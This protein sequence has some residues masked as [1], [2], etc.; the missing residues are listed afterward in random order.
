M[1]GVIS[2]ARVLDTVVPDP[3][4]LSPLGSKEPAMT[5]SVRD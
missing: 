5:A 1:P 2:S 3:Q 4:D